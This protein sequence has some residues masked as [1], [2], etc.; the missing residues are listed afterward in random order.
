MCSNSGGSGLGFRI[1]LHK[2]L[3]KLRFGFGIML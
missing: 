1:L 3:V 2:S